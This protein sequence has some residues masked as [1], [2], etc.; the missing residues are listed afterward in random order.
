MSRK[1]WEAFHPIQA[2]DQLKE[3]TARYVKEQMDRRGQRQRFGAGRRPVYA[4]CACAVLLVLLGGY[5][6]YFTPTAIISIDI[7]PSVELK[8]NRFDRVI[9]VDGYNQDGAELAQSLNVLHEEYSQALDEIVA[10][11]AVQ[12]CL[13]RDELLSIAVVEIDSAQSEAILQYAA[14]CTAGEPNAY[15]YGIAREEV[16]GAHSLGLSYG[17]YR[18]YLQL[19]SQGIRLSPEQVGGMTMRQLKELLDG[20]ETGPGGGWG[21]CGTGNGYGPGPGGN[22]NR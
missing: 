5:R 16:A 19:Q 17:K 20:S 15:C 22:H 10:S 3:R 18:V 11:G 21:G 2:D 4:A 7:N 13:G 1:I 8:I 12:D 9:A 6:V 14:Q